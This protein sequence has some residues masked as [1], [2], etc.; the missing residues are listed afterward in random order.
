MACASAWQVIKFYIKLFVIRIFCLNL[1]T[2][3]TS[4]PW[5]PV[6]TRANQQCVSLELLKILLL[7][8]ACVWNWKIL[9][10][11]V[12]VTL[13]VFYIASL[14]KGRNLKIE[15]NTCGKIEYTVLWPFLWT[16]LVLSV[17]VEGFDSEVCCA[18]W[19][20]TGK[21]DLLGCLVVCLLNPRSAP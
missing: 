8:V 9:F 17:C 21:E 16:C 11:G 2:L 1:K 12:D 3:I 6:C 15:I 10:L 19:F 7:S 5:D 4:V 13:I 18:E 14:K 20:V